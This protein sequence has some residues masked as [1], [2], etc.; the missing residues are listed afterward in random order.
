MDLVAKYGIYRTILSRSFMSVGR[1]PGQ[2]LAA[3]ARGD[4]CLHFGDATLFLGWYLG[5]LATEFHLLASGLMTAPG[6]SPRRSLH[7]LGFALRTLERLKRTAAT[8]FGPPPPSVPP[9]ARGFFIRDD[10]DYGLLAHLPDATSLESDYLNANPYNKEESQDQLFHLLLGLSLVRKFIPPRTFE[11]R[12][13]LGRA[14]RLAREICAWPSKTRWVIRNPYAGGKKVNR[15]DCAIFF[16]CPV[17][18][19]LEEI[20]PRGGELGTSVRWWSKAAWKY[21]M[22]Y[23][24]GRIYSAT[25]LHLVMSLACQSDTWGRKTLKRLVRLSRKFD[26]PVY[27][28]VNIALFADRDAGQPRLRDRLL[29]RASAML[30]AAPPDG[31]SHS[32]SPAGWKASHRFLFERRYQDQGQ[33]SYAGKRFPGLDFLLLHNL[34]RIL[35]SL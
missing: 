35:E 19:A 30:E 7:E 11:M 23:N 1:G 34:F 22:R 17:V 32:G 31:L 2:T 9:E 29:E 28:M 14:R 18:K 10:V 3:D 25:N 33:N 15:G 13:I 5:V 8:A 27:P 26:W 20:D 6:L 4:S 24:L 12:L 16:S 21:L